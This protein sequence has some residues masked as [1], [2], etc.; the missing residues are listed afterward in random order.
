MYNLRTHESIIH[1]TWSN[2]GS[3]I[4]DVHT[5]GSGVRLRWMHVDGG[6]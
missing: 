2:K 1:Y 3:S 4:Y 6:K 5:E